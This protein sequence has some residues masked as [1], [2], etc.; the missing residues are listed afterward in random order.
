MQL[1][2]FEPDPRLA[3]LLM[4]FLA[5]DHDGGESHLPARVCPALMLWVRG[6]STLMEADGSHARIARFTLNGAVM[7]SHR[8][9]IEPGSLGIFVMFRPGALQRVLGIAA[10]D[11]TSRSIPLRTVIDAEQVDRFLRRI[12]QG[13]PVAACVQLLQEFLLG[14]FDPGRKSGI[15]AA[16]TAEHRKL[17]FPLIELASRFGIGE[18]QFERKVMQDFGLSLRELRRIARFGLT[19]PHLL[20]PDVGR[21][22]LTDVAHEAGYYDQ[23]HMHRDFTELGGL[24]PLQLVQKIASGDPAYWLYRIPQPD[25]N[26]LFI[27]AN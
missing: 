3:P 2:V 22:A 14:L 25:F 8:T 12:D 17:F 7:A 4:H 18:R 5:V 1:H 20:Q 16:L 27:P 9:V 19:L 13:L 10:P 15:A 6:G 21:G 23:A 11:V 26:R 24:P